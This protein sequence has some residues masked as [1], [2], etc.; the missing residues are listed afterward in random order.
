[1]L[2]NAVAVPFNTAA[3]GATLE[4]EFDEMVVFEIIVAVPFATLG[5]AVAAEPDERVTVERMVCGGLVTVLVTFCPAMREVTVVV[6]PGWVRMMTMTCTELEEEEELEL[7]EDDEE[8]WE[9]E[10]EFESE[11][12]VSGD[13][14]DEPVSLP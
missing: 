13:D 6:V 3:P 14:D 7:L 11:P 1:V 8:E 9:P 4:L 2:F 12:E 5:I 10:F